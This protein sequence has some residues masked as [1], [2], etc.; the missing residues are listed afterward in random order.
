V[1]FIRLRMLDGV[2]MKPAR[3]GGLLMARRQIDIVND[4]GLMW[5]ASGLTDPTSH[6]RRRS[7]CFPRWASCGRAR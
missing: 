5:L 6:W 7:R 2:A 4:A 1:E 3:C